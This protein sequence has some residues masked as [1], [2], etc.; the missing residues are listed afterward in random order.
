MTFMTL[1]LE[2]LEEDVAEVLHQD[3]QHDIQGSIYIAEGSLDMTF[4]TQLLDLLE[5]CRRSN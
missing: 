3:L 5:T 1:S 4:M 2:G